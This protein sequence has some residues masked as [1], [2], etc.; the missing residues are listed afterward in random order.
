MSVPGLPTPPGPGASNLEHK[1]ISSEHI[2]SVLH[3]GGVDNLPR[4][5]ERRNRG[6]H[7]DLGAPRGGGERDVHDSGV[8]SRGDDL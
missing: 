2:T 7:G 5:G 1:Q 6:G 8:H 4:E 3:V